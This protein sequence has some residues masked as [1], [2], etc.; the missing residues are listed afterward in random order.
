VAGLEQLVYFASNEVVGLD[1]ATGKRLWGHGHETSYGLNIAPPVTGD[2]GLLLVSSAYSGGTRALRLTRDGNKT[3]VQELWFTNQMRV[4][5]GNLIRIGGYAYGSS[6]DFGPTPLS[7]V[8]LRTG[9]VVWRDRAFAKAKLLLAGGR[10][11]VLDEDGSLG[12]VTMS[13]QGLQV[14]A[15]AEIFSGRSW[16]FP[17]L[18]GT[19]LYLRDRKKMLALDLAG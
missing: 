3:R 16:T 4:H 8:D 11:I 9:E 6:G 19:R 18:V 2:D 12:L 10:L 15:R 17:T 5:H 13:P 7:A 1:P 14:Q